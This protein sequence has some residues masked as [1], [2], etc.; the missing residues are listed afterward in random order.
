MRISDLR[1]SAHFILI[2]RS[3]STIRHY[4]LF[5]SHSLMFHKSVASGRRRPV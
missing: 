3:D 2:E 1:Y 4:S 5:I